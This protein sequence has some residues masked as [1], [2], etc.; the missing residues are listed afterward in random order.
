MRINFFTKFLTN[1]WKLFIIVRDCV[2]CFTFHGPVVGAMYYCRLGT[3]AKKKMLGIL[4]SPLCR[5]L[6]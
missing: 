5:F 3:W 1:F 4:L 6:S 2:T